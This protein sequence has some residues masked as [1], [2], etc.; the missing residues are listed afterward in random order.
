[1]FDLEVSCQ[2]S[3]TWGSDIC[4]FRWRKALSKQCREKQRWSF[5]FMSTP[6]NMPGENSLVLISWTWLMGAGG[7]ASLANAIAIHWECACSVSGV[8]AVD[9]DKD[10][11]YLIRLPR[12]QALKR[13]S[14]SDNASFIASLKHVTVLPLSFWP[15]LSVRVL[16]QI[17]YSYPDFNSPLKYETSLSKLS[18]LVKMWLLWWTDKNNN[19][20]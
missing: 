1:M 10:L 4:W 14:R 17:L 3:R 16:C 8:C 2:F 6:L 7:I 11:F 18:L 5:F 9:I 13:D 19:F 15:P 12:L 20:W